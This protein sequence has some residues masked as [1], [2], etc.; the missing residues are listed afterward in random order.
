V[1]TTT[2]VSWTIPLLPGY[3]N[4]T[5]TTEVWKKRSGGCGDEVPIKVGK[6]CQS[7]RRIKRKVALNTC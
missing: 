1:T 5:T 6:S 4:T 2:T 7:R 3:S